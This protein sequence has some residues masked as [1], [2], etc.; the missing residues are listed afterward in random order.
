[1]IEDGSYIRIRNVNL[2]YNVPLN[3]NRNK[4]FIRSLRVFLNAQN[5]KNIQKNSGFSPESGGSAIEFG[6]DRGL[7]PLPAIYS[8]GFNATF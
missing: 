4:S 6:V 1:M 5:L 2:G 7:Y 3:K 8:F